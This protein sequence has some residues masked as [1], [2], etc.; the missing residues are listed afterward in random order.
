MIKITGVTGKHA[1]YA[2]E[3]GSDHDQQPY[4]R[5]IR[6]SF[7]E[8]SVEQRCECVPRIAGRLMKNSSHRM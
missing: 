5:V 7:D 2:S 1:N 3:E 8:C 4:E 6:D